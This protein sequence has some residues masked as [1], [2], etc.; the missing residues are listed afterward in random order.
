M[1]KQTKTTTAKV[2]KTATVTEATDYTKQFATVLKNW[3]KQAGSKV[4]NEMLT[5][6]AGMVKQ[7]GTSKHMALAMYFRPEGAIQPEVTMVTGDTGNNVF[8]DAWRDKV[9]PATGNPPAI[10]VNAEKRNGPAGKALTVYKLAL[11]AKKAAKVTKPR[12]AKQAP[13]APAETPAPEAPAAPEV[14]A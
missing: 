7:T 4:T 14:N 3:P 11:P 10:K 5:I 13:K 1:A 2:T 6:A 9:D 8:N 12:K